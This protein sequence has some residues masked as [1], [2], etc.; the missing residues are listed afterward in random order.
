MRMLGQRCEAL[1]LHTV[2]SR[3]EARF[4]EALL[5][6]LCVTFTARWVECQQ[7]SDKSFQELL[8]NDGLLLFVMHWLSQLELYCHRRRTTGKPK[9]RGC[10][11]TA[12]GTTTRRR[13]AL[14]TI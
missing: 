12:G 9:L 6:P 14:V 1:K 13:N 4:R 7:G 2:R 10:S 5:K 8:C 11:V 3:C